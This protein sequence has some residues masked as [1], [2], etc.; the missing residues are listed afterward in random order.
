[1]YII[2]IL[3]FFFINIG[4]DYGSKIIPHLTKNFYLIIYNNNNENKDK[5]NY[6]NNK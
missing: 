2:N 4:I 6:N 5:N 3:I 1:M